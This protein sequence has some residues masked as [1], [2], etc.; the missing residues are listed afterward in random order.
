[1]YAFFYAHI[2]QI[3]FW[4]Y[5][6][7]H[8]YLIY[9]WGT[10]HNYTYYHRQ[11]HTRQLPV[12]T[13]TRSALSCNDIGIFFSEKSPKLKPGCRFRMLTDADHV[14][15]VLWRYQLISVYSTQYADVLLYTRLLCCC[16]LSCQLARDGSSSSI[17]IRA[18]STRRPIVSRCRATRPFGR[19]FFSTLSHSSL[20]QRPIPLVD[21]RSRF[22]GRL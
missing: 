12:L 22:R 16:R 20:Y 15:H 18:R 4:M 13:R 19:I 1:M 2:M 5:H 11:T 14:F 17:Y 6:N 7:H 8:S 3:C 21:Y 10:I 9:L